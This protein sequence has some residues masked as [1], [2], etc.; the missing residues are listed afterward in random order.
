MTES[1]DPNEC[2]DRTTMDIRFSN[3]N[4]RWTEKSQKV[5]Q[6]AMDA[7]PTAVVVVFMKEG[8][9]NVNSAGVSRLELIGALS[10]AQ[11]DVWDA[12]GD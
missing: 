4:D 2:G 6:D 7:N 3:A 11:G 5:L 12:T 8:I 1:A 9:I 10:A